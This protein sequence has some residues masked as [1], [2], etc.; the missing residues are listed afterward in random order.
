MLLRRLRQLPE[1]VGSVLVI[2][3]NPGIERLATDL[4]GSGDHR[5]LGRMETKY[6]TGGLAT[7]RFEGTWCD[8]EP[9]KAGL[10][11]FVVPKELR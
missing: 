6:P 10:E 7:L 2:G 5:A 4:A 11:A 3:H 9:G 1:I 8:L